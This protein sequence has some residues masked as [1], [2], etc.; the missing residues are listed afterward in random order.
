MSHSVD[1]TYSVYDERFPRARKEHVC[2]ACRETIPGGA[3]YA[4]VGIVFGGN[5]YAV[6]RCLRCQG[7]HEHLRR[8]DPG[9]MWPDEQLNCGLDYED[10][11][12]KPPPIEVAELAFLLPGESPGALIGS[13][14][15]P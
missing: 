7:I 13:E 11:W 15:T 14:V 2:E 3:R 6:K 12:G 8:L 4:R 1:E 5:A 9:E 10:E